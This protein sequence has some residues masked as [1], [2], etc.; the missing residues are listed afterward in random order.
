M[1]SFRSPCNNFWSTI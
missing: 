1:Y